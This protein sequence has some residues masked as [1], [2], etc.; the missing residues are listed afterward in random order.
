MQ[1]VVA[2]LTTPIPFPVLVLPFANF[3]L[4]TTYTLFRRLLR[5]EKWYQ[6]HRCHVYQ[7]M[8]DI[9]MSHKKVTSIELAAVVVSCAAAAACVGTDTWL[10]IGVVA[11]VIVGHVGAGFG[12]YKKERSLQAM[13]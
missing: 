10:R 12:V 13:K 9:G 6:A 11:V 4:D 2:H 7:R 3:I 5:G 1:S 8:T